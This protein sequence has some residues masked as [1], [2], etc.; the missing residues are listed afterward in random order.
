MLAVLRAAIRRYVWWE[1]LAAAATWL[2]L[3]FWASLI[4]DWFFEPSPPVRAGL[5]AATAVVLA[6]VLVQFILR[7]L[8][9]PLGNAQMAMLLE[10]R[11]PQLED[12]LLTSVL[13]G[14]RRPDAT[15]CNPDMLARTC[16]QAEQRLAGLALGKV[17]DP[18][19]LRR[20]LTAAVCLAA[21]I[22]AFGLMAPGALGV[23]LQRNLLLADRLWPRSIR[24]EPV[25][26]TDGVAKVATGADFDLV[27]RAF[28]GDT[29][30][31]VL[32]RE[33]EVRYRVE[34]GPRKRQ[35]MKRLGTSTRPR[36]D[37]TA[38]TPARS[39]RN[40]AIRS[41]PSSAPIRLD[42]VGGDYCCRDLQI[43]VA[44]NPALQVELEYHYP[45][46]H[47]RPPRTVPVTGAM[48]VPLGTRL[49]V[50]GRANKPLRRVEIDY[51][52]QPDPSGHG[53][54]RAR[55]SVPTARGPSCPWS[56]SRTTQ[57]SWR[58]STT[59]MA[60]RAASPPF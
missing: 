11:F 2:G 57:R 27:V 52:S 46:L 30:V 36:P 16:R 8:T 31:A 10:R 56:R 25:G 28:H 26:F 6:G 60:S 48:N 9:A 3:A 14:T 24:L 13:L 51:P 7:R 20:K 45:G 58:R 39:C 15:D 29:P 34:E 40:T 32:P 4:G 38:A 42:V 54:W 18:L 41:A 21:A 33:V 23:W 5:L 59:P 37:S 55:P 22:L 12:T 17:F 50:R 44:P 43:Q 35:F 49:V 1:G 19:P 53:G 47:G